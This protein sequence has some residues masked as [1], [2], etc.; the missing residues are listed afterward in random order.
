[1]KFLIFFERIELVRINIIF[2]R[3][4]DF[5]FIE[6]FKITFVILKFNVLYFKSYRLLCSRN[7][8]CKLKNMQYT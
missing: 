8:L 4:I 5:R 7:L 2:G 6:N 1:M 3:N